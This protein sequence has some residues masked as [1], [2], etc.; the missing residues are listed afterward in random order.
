MKSGCAIVQMFPQWFIRDVPNEF[1]Y[2]M[3]VNDDESE[4]IGTTGHVEGE[5]KEWNIKNIIIGAPS[6]ASL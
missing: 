1:E 2:E 4:V 6:L 3:W 5:R